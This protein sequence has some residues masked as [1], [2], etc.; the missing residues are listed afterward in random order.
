MH[1]PLP[2]PTTT[3][4]GLLQLVFSYRPLFS[5]SSRFVV[6]VCS[7][8]LFLVRISLSNFHWA[9]PFAPSPPRPSIS[10][11]GPKAVAAEAAPQ[12]ARGRRSR[13]GEVAVGGVRRRA[14]G[15]PAAGRAV[16]RSVEV[17]PGLG[18]PR[19]LSFAVVFTRRR[20][21]T[22]SRRQ[23]TKQKGG[24]VPFRFQFD[25]LE[26][27][28]TPSARP[29]RPS[30]CSDP[31]PDAADTAAD[32]AELSIVPLA[33]ASR[34]LSPFS[35]TLSPPQNTASAAS[36]EVALGRGRRHRGGQRCGRGRYHP[37]PSERS[38][39]VIEGGSLGRGTA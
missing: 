18:P 35:D 10:D 31:S 24:I 22:P 33:P 29:T 39:C 30:L 32:R 25:R 9:E 27:C 21:R 38:R 11:R 7:I 28:L 8:C 2:L 26:A 23:I 12:R 4:R 34:N 13:A 19:G 3:P 36:L 6:L 37:P 15:R 5:S 1:R 16:G 17:G 14:D 20:P